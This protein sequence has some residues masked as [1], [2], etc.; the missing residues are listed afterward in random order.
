MKERGN[1]SINN[2]IEDALG[3]ETINIEIPSIG[4]VDQI[5]EKNPNKDK[6]ANKRQYLSQSF[7]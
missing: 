5:M 3:S 4:H 1:K 2:Y 6:Y 7:L